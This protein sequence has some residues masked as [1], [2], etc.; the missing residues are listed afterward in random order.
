MGYCFDAG[1][2]PGENAA[3]AAVVTF[4]PLATN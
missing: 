2:R 3:A 4:P 1:G